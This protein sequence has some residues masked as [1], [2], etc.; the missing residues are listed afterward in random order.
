LSKELKLGTT[1]RSQTYEQELGAELGARTSSKELELVAVL[2][3]RSFLAGAGPFWLEPVHFGPAP[4]T[5]LR[6]IYSTGI[7]AVILNLYQLE[8]VFFYKK[9]TGILSL[10]FFIS[11]KGKDTYKKSIFQMEAPEPVHSTI[12]RSWVGRSELSNM[13]TGSA[14]LTSS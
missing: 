8:R 13:W 10:R 9:N 14:K 7:L 3:S 1:A 5:R 4:P 6:T 12:S 11:K 2:R